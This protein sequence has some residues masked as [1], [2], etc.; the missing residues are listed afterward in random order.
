MKQFLK[1][2]QV[3]LSGLAGAIVLVLQQFVGTAVFNWKVV[4][5]ALAM[6]VG[7]YIGNNL[8]GKGVSIAGLIG[9]AGSAIA[10]I[11]ASGQFSWTQ[12]GV[13][14]AIGFLALVAHPAPAEK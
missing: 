6:G 5:L 11:A 12:F 4:L 2:N 9:T 13:T 14:F 1:D 10:T 8:K 7:G 3:F